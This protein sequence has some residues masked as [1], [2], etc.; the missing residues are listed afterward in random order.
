MGPVAAIGIIKGKPFPPDARMKK[1]M[2]EAL[3]LAKTTSRN[4]SMSLRD[5]SL[6]VLSELV[7]VELLFVTGYEFETPIPLVQT[8]GV[9]ANVHHHR[10]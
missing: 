7:G 1:I 6:V 10:F 3:A 2:T 9:S 4:L 8:P 5:P